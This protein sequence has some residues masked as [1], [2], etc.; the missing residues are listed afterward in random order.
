MSKEEFYEEPVEKPVVQAVQP[1]DEPVKKRKWSFWGYG[2]LFFTVFYI[3]LMFILEAAIQ[4]RES[5]TATIVAYIVGILGLA[6]FAGLVRDKSRVLISIPILLIIV[7]GTGYLFNYVAQAPVYNPLAPVSERTGT[8]LDTFEALNDTEIMNQ[9]P[10]DFPVEQIEFYSQFAFVIDLI[11]ALPLFIFGT[12][13]LTWFT[14][15]F[16]QLPK[17]WTIFSVLFALIFFLIGLVLTPFIHLLFSS[18]L[19]LGSDLLPGALYVMEGFSV[20]QNGFG[21]MTQEEIN[22]AI[23]AFY[24]ASAYFQQAAINLEGLQKA[25][26][27]GLASMIPVLGTV[28]SNLYFFSLAAL[29]L[30]SGL[31][32]FANGTFHIMTGLEDAMEAMEGS[33]PMPLSVNEEGST[34]VKSVIN[35]TLFNDAIE[36]VNDGLLILGNSTDY[37]EQALEDLKHVSL[38]DIAGNISTIPGVPAE[39]IDPLMENLELVEGYLGMFEGGVTV[40]NA[41]LD[42][43]EI[44]PGIE[45]NYATLSHFLYGAYNLF[46]AG[47]NIAN[48]TDFEGTEENFDYSYGNFSVVQ[49]RLNQPDI[50]QVAESDTLFLNS[51]VSFV[52]D[53]VN[54]GVPLCGLGYSLAGG[55][56][57]MEGLLSAFDVGYENVTNYG[58]LISNIDAIRTT[59]SSLAANATLVDNQ[60]TL[61]ET[62]AA[63]NT[64]GELNDIAISFT[65][66]LSAFAFI[67]YVQNANYIVNALYYTFVGMAELSYVMGNVTQIEANLV[68]LDYAAVNA[69]L[70]NAENS[71]SNAIS[72]LT[73]AEGYM[74]DAVNLGG[75]TQLSTSLAAIGAINSGLGSIQT[76]IDNLQSYMSDPVGNSALIDAELASLLSNLADIN[77]DLQDV[78]AQ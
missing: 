35:D 9:L 48:I 50:I 8:L 3:A 66:Q 67:E 46:K 21:N 15:I 25:G 53:M 2:L 61:V 33:F 31:G 60:I 28:V 6:I 12:L 38:A 65:E 56:V 44:S 23:A 77:S 16:T 72:N 43:P 47:D 36:V 30:S 40:I 71:L 4:P 13:A 26:I 78:T 14:Q 7:F 52:L 27:I 22:E 58:E 5:M 62:K 73:L 19:I 39:A 74:D 29:H 18:F 20:F 69:S 37:I 51:T 57:D 11:I 55:F 45:S 70:L 32:P 1:L 41:L 49:N 17:I 64:Y 59:T 68:A 42:K 63:N 75:M 34:T 24:T 10:E 54:I 76:N